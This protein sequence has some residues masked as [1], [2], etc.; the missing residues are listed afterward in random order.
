MSAGGKCVGH[1]RAVVEHD[2]LIGEH[3][4]LASGV[5]LCGNVQIGAE[6]HVGAGAT[7]IQGIRIGANVC[8]GAGSVVLRDIPDGAKVVGVPAREL[9][10]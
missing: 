6:T 2:C 1:T 8:I 5:V 3:V 9:C 7:V 10:T 4:H